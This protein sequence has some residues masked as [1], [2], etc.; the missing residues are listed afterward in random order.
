MTT[1]ELKQRIGKLR[2]QLGALS[3]EHRLLLNELTQRTF[4]LKPGDVIRRSFKTK[5]WFRTRKW[6]YHNLVTKIEAGPGGGV[7]LVYVKVIEEDGTVTRYI[8]SI[9][10]FDYPHIQRLGH[11]EDWETVERVDLAAL[12]EDNA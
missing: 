12:E 2:A 9:P 11:V 3:T 4:W 6:Y 5:R 1:D 10:M 8:G 7:P